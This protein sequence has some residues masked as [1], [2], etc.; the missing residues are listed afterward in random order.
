[1]EVA[2]PSSERCVLATKFMNY[3]L[4]L[5]GNTKYPTASS[6]IQ[7]LRICFWA[8]NAKSSL[9]CVGFPSRQTKRAPSTTPV[10]L[11]L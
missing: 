9:R 11:P 4:H 8:P 1:M 3:P 10:S 6:R 7:R 2:S 5:R